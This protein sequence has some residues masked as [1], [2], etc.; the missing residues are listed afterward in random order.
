MRDGGYGA[1]VLEFLLCDVAHQY[2]YM[3]SIEFPEFVV[4]TCWYVWW[5][6]R[7]VAK[8]EGVQS[9]LPTAHAIQVVALNFDRVA[10]KSAS[11]PGLNHQNKPLAGQ[12]AFNVYAS[13]SEE[14]HSG[15]CGVVVPDH[16]GVLIGASTTKVEHVV[17]TEPSTLLEGLKLRQRIGCNNIIIKMDNIVVAEAFNLN[18]GHSMMMASDS[19]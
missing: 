1:Q 5:Q 6:R 13:F 11:T 10:G 8:E 17:S 18:H 9:P 2:T 7:L 12:H 19:L 3:E 14:D 4:V 16:R 15:Y